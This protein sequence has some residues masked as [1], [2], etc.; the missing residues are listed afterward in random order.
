MSYSVPFFVHFGNSSCQFLSERQVCPQTWNFPSVPQGTWEKVGVSLCW[1]HCVSVFSLQTSCHRVW[2]GLS[3]AWCHESQYKAQKEEYS[4]NGWSGWCPSYGMESEL[5]NRGLIVIIGVEVSEV[6]ICIGLPGKLWVEVLISFLQNQIVFV[7][8]LWVKK[9]NGG[10]SVW[11]KGLFST[12]G[13][14]KSI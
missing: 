3:P 1:Q 14:S 11:I 4:Q 13:K 2:E 8:G 7:E 9:G 10:E 5:P 6:C 12:D